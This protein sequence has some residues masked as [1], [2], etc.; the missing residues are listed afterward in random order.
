MEIW[1]MHW[2]IFSSGSLRIEDSVLFGVRK[3]SREI[4]G[5][6]ESLL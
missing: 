3:G 4:G 1:A 5:L 2:G 6:D